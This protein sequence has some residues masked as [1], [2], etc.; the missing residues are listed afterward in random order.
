MFKIY[1]ICLSVYYSY[2]WKLFF[3]LILC[4]HSTYLQLLP[5]ANILALDFTSLCIISDDYLSILDYLGS[6][7]IHLIPFGIM[8]FTCY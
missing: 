7:I 8:R 5:L 2:T 6:A 1:N 3:K 4:I